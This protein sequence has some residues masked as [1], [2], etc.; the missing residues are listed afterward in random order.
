MIYVIG[1]QTIPES[2]AFDRVRES[3]NL[4][5]DVYLGAMWSKLCNEPIPDGSVIYNME[6]LS[7]DCR[8]FSIGYFEIL[9]KNIVLD[10][11]KNN[12]KYLKSKGIDAFYLPYGYHKS[13]ER[14][15][16]TE[17][18]IDFLL[19]GSVNERRTKI[20]NE[21]RKSFDV[22]WVTGA[23]GFQL[24]ALI[25]MSKVIL[26]IHHSDNHPLEIVRLNYL[27]ANHCTVVSERSNDAELD[28]KYQDGIYFADHLQN[29]CNH[30]LNYPLDGYNCIKSMPMDCHEANEW[31]R[32][33]LC[34]GP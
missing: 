34:L 2:K 22:V 12:V 7:D 32:S 26:N 3:L 31:I 1:E 10:Y 23:Y 6:P 29:M 25:G 8:A 24:D 30:A 28:K 18:T 4:D 16:P 14:I 5:F 9:Q 13:L 21:L 33:K 11:C 19:V 27:M 15:N 17:K 20:V